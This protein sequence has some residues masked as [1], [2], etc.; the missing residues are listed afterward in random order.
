MWSAN[1]EG[2]IRKKPPTF[3]Y[4]L[5]KKGSWVCRQHLAARGFYSAC[6]VS[7]GL[8][9]LNQ[10]SLIKPREWSSDAFEMVPEHI[11]L[12]FRSSSEEMTMI[13]AHSVWDLNWLFPSVCKLCCQPFGLASEGQLSTSVLSKGNGMQKSRQFL[14]RHVLQPSALS[15]SPSLLNNRGMF[16]NVSWPLA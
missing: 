3:R 12:S 8:V 14:I 15:F 16:W 10:F 6:N 5:P 13:R 9:S 7:K 4:S 1:H 11:I 2:R